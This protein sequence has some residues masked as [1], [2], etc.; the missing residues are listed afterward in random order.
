MSMRRFLLKL[1][2]L[3]I[4]LTLPSLL[5]AQSVAS[6]TGTVTDTSGAVVPDANVELV[7]SATGTV[8]KVKTNSTGSYTVPN[9]VPGPGYKVTFSREG[10]ESVVI[11]GL[12]LNVDVTRT[13]N[14]RLPVGREA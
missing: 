3:T 6:M 11:S 10:F 7:N 8:Y 12:Y 13:Q 5:R 9:V 2:V 14:A 1:L 4:A